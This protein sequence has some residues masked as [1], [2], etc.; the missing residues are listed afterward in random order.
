[1]FGHYGKIAGGNI[2]PSRFVKLGTDETVTHCG[3]GEIPWGISQPYTRY[4]ALAAVDDG[5]AA[6]A[7]EQCNV[8]GPTDDECLLELGGT[9]T[10]GQGIKATTDGKGLAA[11]TNLD[12]VGAVAIQGGISGDLIKVKPMRYDVSV[13]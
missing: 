3:A 10:P 13:A 2:A 1:M 9:V 6:I 8:F 11:V 5:F 12:Q 7:G 4:P